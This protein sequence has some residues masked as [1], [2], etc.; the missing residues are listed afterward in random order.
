MKGYMELAL[1]AILLVLMY[2]K[3]YALT[4]MANSLLGKA[5]MIIG[6][7]IIAKNNGLASGLLAA[8]IMIIL[9]HETVEGMTTKKA[10][11]EPD[12]KKLGYTQINDES[13]VKN[14]LKKAGIT[15]VSDSGQCGP[16]VTQ[17][18]G[19]T[20]NVFI[21]P[22]K[23]K[24]TK[25]TKPTKKETFTDIRMAEGFRNREAYQNTIESMK[26][27]NGQ[28]GAGQNIYNQF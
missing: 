5:V 10:D 19:T 16:C 24:P 23:T 26:F 17:K 8:L 11:A 28:T 4:E 14:A 21:K 27:S 7:G 20:C 22:E 12:Y 2:E 13:A 9:I 1:G 18:A 15:K 25:P 6:V 3:P